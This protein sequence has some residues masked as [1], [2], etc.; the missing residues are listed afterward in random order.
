[1]TDDIDHRLRAAAQAWRTQVDAAATPTPRSL[2][3]FGRAPRRPM[4]RIVTAVAAA[5]A[6]ALVVSAPWSLTRLHDNR[7]SDSVAS[8]AAPKPA[9]STAGPATSSSTTSPSVTSTTDVSPVATIVWPRC[10][11][12]GATANRRI[13]AADTVTEVRVCN[14]AAGTDAFIT[15]D[16]TTADMLV[17][18]LRLDDSARSQECPAHLRAQPLVEVALQSGTAFVAR[19]PVGDCGIRQPAQSL[20]DEVLTGSAS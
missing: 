13:V 15:V 20:I 3:R 7:P 1:M 2:E 18:A 19:L 12:A 4:R 10:S 17:S 5:A 8:V 9:T 11:T 16:A 14:P 6:V